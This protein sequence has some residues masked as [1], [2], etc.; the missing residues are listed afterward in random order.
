MIVLSAGMPRAGSGW[1]FN[2]TNDLMVASDYQNVREIRKKYYLQ[3][4]LTEVNC[5]IGALTF[6]RLLAVLIP[7]T[8]GNSFVVKTHAGPTPNASRLISLGVL[9]PAYIYRDPRDALLSAYENGKRARDRGRTN[10]FSH[11]N[12]FE[13]T[14]N[15]ML[16][17][18]KIWEAWMNCSQALVSQYEDLVEKY[19][20]ETARLISFLGL[21]TNSELLDSVLDRYRPGS[22]DRNHMGMHFRK[23]KIG[24][25]RDVMTHEQQQTMGRVFGPY[26]DRMGYDL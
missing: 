25:F 14:L 2:L 5:N 19:D 6:H 17:Y 11:L 20:V 24:R 22:I 7:S 9:R 23:G 15:F 3:R 12:D 8:L 18:V 10:A 16:D 13:S 21:D 4:I 26:L 1:Y